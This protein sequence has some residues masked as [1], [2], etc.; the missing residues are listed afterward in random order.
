MHDYTRTLSSERSADS[1]TYAACTAGDEHNFAMKSSFHTVRE[2]FRYF[3]FSDKP[4]N[5]TVSNDSGRN[6]VESVGDSESDREEEIIMAST[7]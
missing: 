5:Q 4:M 1:L 3:M 7:L 2:M 6:I